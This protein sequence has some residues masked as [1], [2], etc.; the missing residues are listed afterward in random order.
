MAGVG[1]RQ[2]AKRAFVAV[3]LRVA[4]FYKLVLGITRDSPDDELTGAYRKV[5]RR[6]HPDKGGSVEHQTQ[7]NNAR[8][9][10]HAARGRPDTT[11]QSAWEGNGAQRASTGTASAQ[12]TM[13]P[14]PAPVGQR[15]TPAKPGGSLAKQGSADSKSPGGWR[16]H[17]MAVLLTYNGITDLKQWRRFL[18]FVRSEQKNWNVRHWCATLEASKKG[19]YH[20]HLMLQFTKT[21]DRNSRSFAFEAIPPNC[22]PNGAGTDL[23][24]SCI[25]GRNPQKSVDRG[26][27]YVWADKV[28]TV[29]DEKGELCVAGNYYP[30]WR[31]DWDM[32]YEVSARWV[33]ALWRQRKLSHEVYKA[34]V[35]EA[36]EGVQARMKNLDTVVEGKRAREEEAEMATTSKRIRCNKNLY[37]PFPDVPQATAW[38]QLFLLDAIRYPLLLV[39]G[40]SSSGKTEWAKSL[41]KN[42]LEMKVGSL[43]HFPDKMR[44]F[45]R[46]HHD[47]IVLDDVRDLEFLSD[48]QEKLQGKYDARVEFASTPGGTCS[49]HKYLFKVPTVVTVNYSTKHLEYLETHDW[50]SKKENCVVVH[51]PPP[52]V[53]S[54][55]AL[56]PAACA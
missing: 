44:Q 36:R 47:G 50:L 52:Q 2:A 7:L 21:V 31:E 19:T 9:A 29:R 10:W 38:L 43:P 54:A 37:R 30:C 3:L 23:L 11:S 17:C 16:V 33:D 12:P 51:W 40:A 27:F 41:F 5:A 20:I 1:P 26:M 13:A 42:A 14:Q 56:A 46:Y 53:E 34:Y 4:Q 39:L 15:S 49:F 8:D 18:K 22:S 32:T 55:G 48:H 24:G 45:V 6:A 35:Y 25:G 28:G